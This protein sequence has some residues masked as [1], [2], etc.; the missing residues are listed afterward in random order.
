M[1]ARGV[2]PGAPGGPP[3]PKKGRGPGKIP[4]TVKEM[5]L[6]SLS[7]AGGMEYL[8]RQS[9]ENPSAYMTLLSKI[10]P[11]QVTGEGGGPIVIVTGVERD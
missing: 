1:R 6:A 8:L 3:K 2:P 9:K 5:V 11:M 7:E 10:I 4:A